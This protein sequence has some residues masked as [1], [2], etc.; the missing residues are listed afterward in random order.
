[1][2]TYALPARLKCEQCNASPAGMLRTPSGYICPDCALSEL[3]SLRLENAKLRIEVDETTLKALAIK[4][5]NKKLHNALTAWKKFWDNMPNGQL[6]KIVCDIG[7][8]NEAFCQMD[9]ALRIKK[10]KPK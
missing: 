4:E 8:L 5:E 6:G 7:L 1:M 2:K 10:G 3:Q 9:S